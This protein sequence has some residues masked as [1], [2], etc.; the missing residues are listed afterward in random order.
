MAKPFFEIKNISV[1]GSVIMDEIEN[2][3]KENEE[4]GLYRRYFL[5]KT[6]QFEWKAVCDEAQFLDYYLQAIRRSW[7]VDIND[8][9]I[10]KKRGWKGKAELLFKKIIWKCLKFYTYR[11][12]SQ[13]REFNSQASHTLILLHRDYSEKIA[14]LEADVKMLEKCLLK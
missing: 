4:K 10:P 3:M 9:E 7:A 8:F 6:I 2:R 12:F 13:Q 14:L 11:L 5:G 1:P